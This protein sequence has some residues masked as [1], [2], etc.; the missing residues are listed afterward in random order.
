MFL[1]GFSLEYPDEVCAYDV[2]GIPLAPV[3]VDLYV[4]SVEY[5]V[6]GRPPSRLELLYELEYDSTFFEEAEVDFPPRLKVEKHKEYIQST[7]TIVC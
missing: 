1:Y 2:C 5:S 4:E 6:L 7:M 3:A